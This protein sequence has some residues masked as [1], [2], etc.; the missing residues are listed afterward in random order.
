MSWLQGVHWKSFFHLK[1]QIPNVTYSYYFPK[2]QRALL[3]KMMVHRTSSLGRRT[4]SHL[5]C[6]SPACLSLYP[7]H[8]MPWNRA[9]PWLSLPYRLTGLEE[10]KS[11]LHPALTFRNAS[12]FQNNPTEKPLGEK[13][14]LEFCVNLFQGIAFPR[15]VC[16]Q[17]VE[18]RAVWATVGGAVGW[19]QGNVR[20][21][22]FL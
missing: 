4:S 17:N 3:S 6:Y 8:F 11:L 22:V 15:A 12:G 21:G 18:E 13:Y 1:F 2:F 20:H 10:I 9:K 16:H 7:E 19:L 5:P 14:Q